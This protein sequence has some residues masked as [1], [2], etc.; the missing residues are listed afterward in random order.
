MMPFITRR[1][2]DAEMAAKDALIETRDKNIGF[3]RES[4]DFQKGKADRLKMLLDDA[5]H[6]IERLRKLVPARDAKGHF[7]SAKAI[8]LPTPPETNA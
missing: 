2:H 7:V 1:R 5:H 6:E 8:P 3:I 4:R